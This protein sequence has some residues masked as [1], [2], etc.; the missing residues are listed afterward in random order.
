MYERKA[1]CLVGLGRRRMREIYKNGSAYKRIENIGR[2]IAE[3][4][5]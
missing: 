1:D 5:E 3:N 2:T 4:I